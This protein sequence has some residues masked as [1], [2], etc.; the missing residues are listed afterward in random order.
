MAPTTEFSRFFEFASETTLTFGNELLC[1]DFS[2]FSEDKRVVILA[3]A[4]PCGTTAPEARRSPSSLS[5]LPSLDDVT[6]WTVSMDTGKV[7]DKITFKGDFVYLSHMA[8]VHFYDGLLAVTS[9]QHQTIHVLEVSVGCQ[10]VWSMGCFGAHLLPLF[11]NEGKFSEKRS[12]G[13]L[14]RQDDAEY[15]ERSEE[16]A[17]EVYRQAQARAQAQAAALSFKRPRSVSP[18]SAGSNKRPALSYH[19]LS[20]ETIQASSAEPIIAFENPEPGPADT[21]P[22]PEG[23]QAPSPRVA[24]RQATVRLARFEPYPSASSPSSAAPAPI[25]GPGNA[26]AATPARQW[27]SSWATANGN[28]V[29]SPGLINE[30]TQDQQQQQQEQ[31]DS[32]PSRA[33][34]ESVTEAGEAA[35]LVSTPAIPPTTPGPGRSLSAPTSARPSILGTNQRPPSAPPSQP[36][37]E[38]QIELPSSDAPQPEESHIMSGLKQ[39]I[40]SY[41]YRNAVG[42]GLQRHVRHFHL[43][44]GM[45]SKLVMWR[46][47]FLDADK[48]LLKFGAE[49]NVV[50][51]ADPPVSQTAFFVIYEIS[52]TN[53]LGVYESTS[54]DLLHMYETNPAFRG[55]PFLSDPAQFV[56]AVAN[57]L[58]AR[59]TA[60]R[61][62]HA[63]WKAK[64][65]GWVWTLQVFFLPL[66][67]DNVS[68]RLSKQSPSIRQTH[69]LFPPTQPSIPQRISLLRP[70]ALLLRR[71]NIWIL[72]TPQINRR[73]PPTILE[74]R[75]WRKEI[76][77]GSV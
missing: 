31:R 51:K 9:V 47:Q 38:R 67:T 52:S 56:P 26:G 64:N 45:F 37:Q 42:F 53:V 16:E 48:L 35:G 6:F 30:D 75:N 69:P 29:A 74:P 33:S 28:R 11:Q 62:M 13:W 65:G 34:A 15:L 24:R 77:A 43:V 39:R 49:E 70:I 7:L 46:C 76:R 68:F 27:S 32:L 12:I 36:P 72:G 55:V 2:L 5:I 1:K 19:D 61:Q 44:A 58:W 22:A 50:G 71:K 25:P 23:A 66:V 18:T 14:T 4:V 57:S 63:V 40:L 8:G 3:S 54:D 20:S 21:P 17:K 73:I 41:L 10:C 60:A 59:E